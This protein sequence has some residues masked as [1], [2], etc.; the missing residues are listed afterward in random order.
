LRELAQELGAEGRLKVALATYT[1]EADLLAEPDN[2]PML[3]QAYRNQHPRSKRWQQ[4]EADTDPAKALY[5]RL[6]K[7]KKF[8][9]KGEFAHDIALAIQDGHSFTVPGYLQEA[10][11]SALEEPGEPGA[12]TLAQ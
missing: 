1:L 8:I 2:V 7:T 9:S 6:R 12:A 4:I 5:R 11:T 3:R 10:I